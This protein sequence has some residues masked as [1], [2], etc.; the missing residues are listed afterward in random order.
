M[1]TYRINGFGVNYA[2]VGRVILPKYVLTLSL[3][4]ETEHEIRGYKR[5]R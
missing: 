4:R 2:I 3:S 1:V 5:N